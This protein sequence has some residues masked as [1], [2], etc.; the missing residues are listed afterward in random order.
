MRKDSAECLRN[1]QRTPHSLFGVFSLNRADNPDI[2]CIEAVAN[3][4]SQTC[5]G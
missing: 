1:A 3:R 5:C 4:M 2:K